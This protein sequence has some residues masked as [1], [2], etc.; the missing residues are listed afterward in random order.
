MG[1]TSAI[2]R[3]NPLRRLVAGWLGGWVRPSCLRNIRGSAFLPSQPA[4]QSS[5][6]LLALVPFHMPLSEYV[7]VWDDKKNPRN[8]ERQLRLTRKRG[9]RRRRD[10]HPARTLVGRIQVGVRPPPTSP[11]RAYLMAN[12]STAFLLLLFLISLA[13]DFSLSLLSL[14]SPLSLPV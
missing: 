14:L 4:A 12:E 10:K 3:L 6:P 11:V 7:G 5:S 13:S 9:V 1:N 8:E 2:S